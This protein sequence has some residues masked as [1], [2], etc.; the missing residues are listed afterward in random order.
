MGL[1]LGLTWC[2]FY[3]AT[4]VLAMAPTMHRKETPKSADLQDAKALL[5][6]LT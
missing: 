4:A 2:F 5:N 3:M 6:D 1:V